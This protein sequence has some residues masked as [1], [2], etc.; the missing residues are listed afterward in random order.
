MYL[1]PTCRPCQ[2]RAAVSWMYTPYLLAIVAEF[3][4][5]IVGI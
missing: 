4:G 2:F 5:A 3:V 1:S